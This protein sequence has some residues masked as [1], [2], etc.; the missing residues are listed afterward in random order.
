M[1]LMEKLEAS[2]L[3]ETPQ[4]IGKSYGNLIMNLRNLIQE[5]IDLG[6][7]KI[8]LTKN[9][10]KIETADICYY[11]F[12]KNKKI[13]L[14]AELE[15]SPLALIVRLVGKDDQYIHKDPKASKLYEI[16]L[17]DISLPLRFFSDQTLTDEGFGIWTKLFD[18]GYKIAIYD[19][20]NP[21]NTFKQI[22]SKDELKSFFDHDLSYRRY[23][24]VLSE[25]KEMGNLIGIFGIRNY[26][27]LAG[28]IE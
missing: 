8:K 17:K 23:Q 1:D 27:E 10:F 28:I 6:Y 21:G 22:K 12:E 16:I 15:K 9:V 5:A 24:F 20:E 14:A 19:K 11:W 13:I 3:S 2:F 25:N 26:Q 4:N 7:K 18:D